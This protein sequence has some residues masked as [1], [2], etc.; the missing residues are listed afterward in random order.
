MGISSDLQRAIVAR[1]KAAVPGV[2]VYVGD[3]LGVG[4][5]PHDRATGGPAEWGLVDD[6]HQPRMVG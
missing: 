5:G 3:G 6:F 1:L 2:A 4:A